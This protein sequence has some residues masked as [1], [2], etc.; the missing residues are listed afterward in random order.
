MLACFAAAAMGALFPPGEWY[1]TL[2]KPS[3]NPPASVFGPIWATLYAL[4]AAAAWLVWKRGGFEAQGGPL[5]LFVIQLVLNA[6]WTPLF[7]GLH[8]PGVA[9]VEM[10]LLWLALALTVAS[11]HAVS[12]PA[13]WLLAPYLAWVSFAA[14][15]NFAIWR[16][17]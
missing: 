1:A 2:N 16:L 6:L 12:R 3:W 5:G 7:F 17:N 11:F 15:L 10:I 14:V 13:A 8:W 4:M 9:F